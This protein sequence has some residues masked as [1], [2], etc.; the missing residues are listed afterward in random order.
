VGPGRRGGDAF[1]VVGAIRGAWRCRGWAGRRGCCRG[2][3]YAG[4]S[5]RAVRAW[6]WGG[7]RWPVGLWDG[8]S[9]AGFAAGV[10]RYSEA[11]QPASDGDRACAVVARDSVEGPVLLVA[12]DEV[13]GDVCGAGPVSEAD[14]FGAEA[15]P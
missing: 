5:G 6:L 11:A 1:G 8:L 4:G 14:G 2:R 12:F 10:E 7:P 3:W 13:W 15:V 9:V